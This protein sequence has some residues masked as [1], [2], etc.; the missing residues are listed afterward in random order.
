MRYFL[1]ASSTAALTRFQSRPSQSRL[2]QG[3]PLTR[4]LVVCTRL[5]RQIR[6]MRFRCLNL[7]WDLLL[8]LRKYLGSWWGLLVNGWTWA[9]RI[10]TAP[11]W[12]TL[13]IVLSILFQTWYRQ[14]S[15]K[16]NKNRLPPLKSLNIL[17][18]SKN[19]V[20][21]KALLYLFSVERSLNP[22]N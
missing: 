7:S 3:R 1:L 21:Y 18:C 16:L 5:M 8:R 19:N 6:L 9:A 2:S 10:Y 20:W 15:L 4:S 11:Y 17:S 22:E 13:H 14:I 12:I